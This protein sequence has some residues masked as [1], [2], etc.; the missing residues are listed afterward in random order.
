[1]I[2]RIHIMN[3]TSQPS[4]QKTSRKIFSEKSGTRAPW[5]VP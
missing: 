4:C 2:R 1:M 5:L 3:K